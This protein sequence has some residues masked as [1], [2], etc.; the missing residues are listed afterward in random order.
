M[1]T[2]FEYYS[3]NQRSLFSS[4]AEQALISPPYNLTRA[5]LTQASALVARAWKWVVVDEVVFNATVNTYVTESLQKFTDLY[6]LQHQTGRPDDS[7]TTTSAQTTTVTKGGGTTTVT[8]TDPANKVIRQNEVYFDP[9]LQATIEPTTV[10][11]TT[12]QSKET[13][14]TTTS[15]Q[16]VDTTNKPQ[17]VVTV[18]KPSF[19]GHALNA[20]EAEKERENWLIECL[21]YAMEVSRCL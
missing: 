4:V 15:P 3:D 19:W 2:L 21:S 7:V 16:M 1:K 6:A 17:S 11:T 10:E 14:V 20:K 9:Q 13:V 12:N 18:S 5:K 8:T